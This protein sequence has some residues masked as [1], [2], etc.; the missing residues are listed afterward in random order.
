MGIRE[1]LSWIKRHGWENVVGESD[2]GTVV[3]TFQP[4]LS[5]LVSLF[6]LI[7][8]YCKSLTLELPNASQQY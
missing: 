6:G 8:T 2:A 5:S 4:P 3:S 1:A 7:I